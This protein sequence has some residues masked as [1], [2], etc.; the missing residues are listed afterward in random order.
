MAKLAEAAKP[1]EA[2]IQFD[3]FLAG[4]PA[5]VQLFS[6]FDANPQL[7]GLIV[8]ICATAPAQVEHAQGRHQQT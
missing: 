7:T 8:D 5:G 6:L 4:L 2:L 1:D 3:G